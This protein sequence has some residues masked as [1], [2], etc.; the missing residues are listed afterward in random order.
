MTKTVAILGT[1]MA[2]LLAGKAVLE[3]GMQPVLFDMDYSKKTL[4]GLHYL[5]HH[6][7]MELPLIH[8]NNYII[9][10]GA[11]PEMSI[12][13]RYCQKVFGEVNE[14][15]RNNS[16]T[17]LQPSETV[18]CMQTAYNT[19]YEAM[20]QHFHYEE[21][22]VTKDF[23]MQCAEEFDAVVS[24]IPLNILFPDAKCKSEQVWCSQNFPKTLVNHELSQNCVVYNV[25]E[26]ES[27]YRASRVA[28]TTW[29]EFVEKPEDVACFPVNKIV[30]EDISLE[31]VFEQ[32]GI[33]LGGRYGAWNRKELAHDI[34]YRVLKFLG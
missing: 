33:I 7:N 8:I 9:D 20:Q 25:N 3:L 12:G 34:Y 24:T 32:T 4:K 11:Y 13:E 19:L 26:D 17:T 10:D 2:G 15:A 27:W 6:C 14:T 1:G 21:V 18:Y 29:T 23:A 16:I 30:T 5:H 28:G 31:D 22:K